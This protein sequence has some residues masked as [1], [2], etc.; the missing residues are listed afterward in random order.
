M[1]DLRA[2]SMFDGDNAAYLEPIYEAY[3]EDPNSIDPKL[4]A[5]FD[6][7]KPVG[8][9]TTEVA[10]LPIQQAFL[11]YAQYKSQLGYGAAAVSAP[12]EEKQMQVQMLI[13]AYRESG[14]KK[15]K[16]DPLELQTHHKEVPE[17]T[18]AYHHL[19]DA[20]LNTVFQTSLVHLPQATLAEIV[21]HL[22]TI[23]CGT[24]GSEYT[25]VATEAEHEWLMQRLEG[26]L[27]KLQ[28]SPEKEKAILN[29]LNKAEG[30]ERYLH[31]RF[32]GQKR[33]S[34]E[35]GESLIPAMNELIENAGKANVKEIIIGMA[36]RG[37]L[38]VLINTLGKAPGALFQEFEGKA[39]IE[40][41]AGDVKYHQ[42]FSSDIQ[43]PNGVLHL[44]LAFNPSH[45][46]IVSPV[47]EGSVKARQERRHDRE[48]QQVLP[49]LIHGDSAFAGQ[50]VVMETFS[51]SQTRGFTTG[52]TVHI[53][54]N[55]QVG[56]TTSNPRDTRSTLYCTDIAKMIDAPIFH[57]NGDD[58]E[59]VVFLAK[60]ALD[61]RTQF[62]KDVV[63]DL[64]CYRRHGHN[65]ADEPSA[66]QPLM[67][68]KIR[69]H[70]T[71]AAL[72]GQKLI[73]EGVV[74]QDEITVM[75]NNYRA[76]LDSGKEIVENLVQIPPAEM[77][78]DWS[79]YLKQDP[80]QAVDTRISQ[81]EL[82]KLAIKMETVPEG[83]VLQKQV[84]KIVEDRHKMAKGELPID[85]GFAE[86][87]AYASLIH[88]GFAVRLSGQ[89][90]GRGTFAHRH[91]VLHNQ[92]N[93]TP[94]CPLA[95]LEANQPHFEVIDSLLSEEAVLAFEYGYS[96]TTPTTLV[97]WEAQF[98][99]FA[100]GAQV[101]I[102]Q[103]ISSGEHK[104]G[105]LSG[106]TMLLPHGY[107]GMG[108][109]HSSARLERYLQLCAEHNMLVCVP[110]TPAQVFHMLRRQMLAPFRKPLIVMSPKSLLRH[111][112][113][114]STLIELAEGEFK[115]IL[116]EI[117]GI[118]PET[119]T[120]VI[121]CSGKVYYDLLAKRRA[122]N[123]KDVA[124]VRIEQLYPFPE[125]G[126]RQLLA[127]YTQAKQVIW[128][129]EEPQNQ[130]AW[131]CTQHHLRAAL[132][133]H[134]T[135]EYAGRVASSSPAAGYHS[136][137]VLEQ[138]SL[139]EQA[140]GKE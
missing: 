39:P 56:F 12:V 49:I 133:A 92:E 43:T 102:D 40:L 86:N 27:P 120:R 97:A 28:F 18:L 98:G 115:R 94:Y 61:Y 45:L 52:G 11:D 75:E 15:A 62:K 36:H 103:F 19:S 134:Q 14:H 127:Q 89:D 41:V 64:V 139:V 108:P 137:H 31:T 35:G 22:E 81:D 79:P 135:L 51:M 105:R 99:D 117:D 114:V 34:L 136:V 104:W 140:L 77:Q 126:L 128:C 13:D 21:K 72:Y 32:V 33:F 68:T 85:W 129:Q 116:P 96:T 3:L 111:K 122:D 125:A 84:A 44:A 55:N 71:T 118:T 53:V 93:G 110:S 80:V 57:V 8:G 82:V 63:I 20:D 42:G 123:R 58:P 17:L 130:G 16:L 112:L 46:E 66:T 83:F 87:L 67:Y 78:V 131:Y 113:A 65:E 90:C 5:Q 50:G 138:N 60:L 59:A 91:A 107:E 70:L 9:N 121:L 7:L 1:Q 119:A 132:A 76:H 25:H 30:L 124:I 4:R 48:H 74:S 26:E 101:V 54:I 38:N 6:A 37:R 69:N 106:L 88:Q 47:V 23:Y 95:H 24:I 2:S 100:N 10:H 73:S 29:S 109:E